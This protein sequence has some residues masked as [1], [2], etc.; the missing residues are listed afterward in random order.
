MINCLE[1]LQQYYEPES[2]A[3]RLLVT[4]SEQVA[5]LAL[6]IAKAHPELDIDAEFVYEAAMLHDVGIKHTHAPSILCYGTEPY[7]KHGVLGAEM[8]R[9]MGLERHARVCERHTGSGLSVQEIEAQELPLPHKDFL[10]ETIEE[11]L[12]CYADKFFSKSKI[13]PAKPVE[14]VRKQ[15]AA[16]GSESLARFDAMHSLFKTEY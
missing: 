7:I 6:E 8:L 2:D 14:S 10:P 12:V 1:I 5:T 9:A 11:K 15:M 16:F 3:F 4:H 13:A